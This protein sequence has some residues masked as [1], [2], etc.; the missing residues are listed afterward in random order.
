MRNHMST[1]PL[2]AIVGAD[3]FVGSGLAAALRAEKVVYGPC[4][5][6]EV[7]ISQAEGVL[8]K[9][10]VIIN[11]GGFRVRPGCTYA[12]YQ[13]SHQGATSAFVPWIRKGA[14]LIHF[15]SA[16]VLGKSPEQKLG[17]Q[18]PPDPRSFPSPAYALAKIEA[19]QFLQQAAAERD[20]R[21]IFLRPA[22]VYAPQGAG[23]IDTLIKMAKR[24]INLRL[25][26]REARHH[27]C[28]M[29][30]LV[31]AMRRVIERHHLLHLSCLV[32][33]D[34]YTVTSRELEAMLTRY[35]PKRMM[36]L[37]IP[38]SWL[39]TLLR[40]SFHS[41]HPKLDLATWG[42]IFGVLHMDTVYDPFDTFRLLEIDSAQY[43]LEKTLQP[44]IQQA[45]Q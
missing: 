33:A 32:V 3:G 11:A 19:D 39:S 40:H 34:P 10:D 4:R 41:K 18:T 2:I 12:D 29:S 14:L 9:A 31:E 45:F 21:V 8:H 35:S 26:P 16:S 20:F 42:E 15:S 13:R 28:H 38:V 27:L 25:Y 43:S 1:K 6:G 5:D 7:S 44:L 24:G 23:M 36:P 17:N 30:L 37:P 22:V